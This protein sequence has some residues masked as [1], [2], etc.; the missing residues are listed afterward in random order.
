MATPT[1]QKINAF[2]ATI[3]T[4]IAFAVIGGTQL[5]RSSK[6]IIYDSDNNKICTH[7][8]S[9]TT[10]LVHNLPANTDSSMVYETGKSASDFINGYSYSLELEIYTTPDASGT[11]EGKSIRMQFWCLEMPTLV[12]IQPTGE[13]TT[14]GTSSYTFIANC[15]IKFPTGVVVPIDNKVQKYKFDLYKGVAEESELVQTTGDIYGTGNYISEHL[16]ALSHTFYNLE[17]ARVY[18]VELTVTTEQGM[19]IPV[20]RSS[21]ITVDIQDIALSVA[22]VA[23]KP[24]E[25]Y[26]EI[27]SNITNIL[28]HTNAPYEERSGHLDLSGSS[29]YYVN[30]G[31]DPEYPL[32]FPPII[33]ATGENAMRWS[34]VAMANNCVYSTSNPFV[35]DDNTYFLKLSNLNSNNGVYIYMRQDDDKVWAELYAFELMGNQP[36]TSFIVSNKLENITEST[37]VY[38]LIRC[39]YGWYDV[40]L[41]TELPPE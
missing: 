3:G 34:I 39:E 12:F 40:K 11:S 29:D 31:E 41:T 7:V 35:I 25:G 14:V 33:T 19:A 32:E 5:I 38:M 8:A 22:Q 18:Y 13:L 21:Y 6:V 28:G 36:Y 15:T 16:Y 4:R 26:I 2:D 17:N 1:I 10:E 20:A 9:V 37:D 23:N 30:W 27:I 24:C